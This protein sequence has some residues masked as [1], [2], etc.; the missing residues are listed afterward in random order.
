MIQKI[1]TSQMS[2]DELIKFVNTGILLIHK[3]ESGIYLM[4]SQ[5]VRSYIDQCQLDDNIHRNLYSIDDS[6]PIFNLISDR[7]QIQHLPALLVIEKSVVKE[8]TNGPISK[9]D[10]LSYI[11]ICGVNEKI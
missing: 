6:H 7:F 10:L 4:L 2:I 9:L 3:K 8:V 11:T 1:T 5:S